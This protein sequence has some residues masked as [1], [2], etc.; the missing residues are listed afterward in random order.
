MSKS[1]QLITRFWSAAGVIAIFALFVLGFLLPKPARI[2]VDSEPVRA[3]ASIICIALLV[4]SWVRQRRCI[5]TWQGL[6]FVTLVLCLPA[7]AA[8]WLVL[9][10]IR[11]YSYAPDSGPNVY[12][13]VIQL[14][15][16]TQW[17]GAALGIVVAL[18]SITEVARRL[19]KRF[20]PPIASH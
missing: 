12:S 16:V 10:V 14:Q 8:F 11:F 15:D 4:H 17:C 3:V 19:V 1:A 9:N 18:W 2:I 5:R 20:L 6:A 13:V 7:L